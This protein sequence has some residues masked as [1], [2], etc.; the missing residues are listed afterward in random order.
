MHQSHKLG[1]TMDYAAARVT[2]NGFA[3]DPPHNQEASARRTHAVS[4]AQ[5]WRLYALNWVWNKV[6]RRQVMY[7][8][9][10]CLFL[11]AAA[12]GSAFV[13][14]PFSISP[15]TFSNFHHYRIG[16]LSGQID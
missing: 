11:S 15:T 12:G 3:N 13:W 1:E 10:F 9:I 8:T 2:P 5:R 7:L 4:A 14:M 6:R 16:I